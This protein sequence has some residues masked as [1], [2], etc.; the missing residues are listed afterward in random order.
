MLLY[1]M[2]EHPSVS[3]TFVVTEAA[4]VRALGVP[5]AG[6]A[7]NRGAAL[8]PAAELDFL[9]PPPGRAALVAGALRS[10]RAALRPL[11]RVA[12]RELSLREAV[13]VVLAEAHAAHVVSAARRVGVVHVHAHFLGRSADVADALARR[14]GC[15][16]TV[17]AHA[18]DVYVPPEPGLLRDR[19]ARTA[20]VA[21]ASRNVRQTVE[22]LAAGRPVRTGIVHCGVDLSET[23]FRDE[24]PAGGRRGLVTVGRLVATKGYWTILAS[25]HDLLRRHPELHW[26]L[27][28]DGP[29]RD[30]LRADPRFA[31]L[32]PRLVLAGA[33]D[34]AQTLDL[35]RTADAFV[36]PSERAADGDSD[37]IP[38][39]LM[40]AMGLGVPVVTTAVGG[41]PELVVDGDTGLVVP[42]SDPAALTGA[43]ERL[44]YSEASDDVERMRRA[45]R[46][47][48]E[49]EFESSGQAE[50]LL[51]LL[52]PWVPASPRAI[53]LST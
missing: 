20:A 23:T 27:V 21:C 31:D 48:V 44:L 17:T 28:G 34:H 24:H 35:I 15:R 18:A 50:A 6:Y 32:T 47:K 52:R 22:R 14:L 11:A 4:A 43:L 42:E 33:L 53:A 29:L 49:R 39:A 26:T 30:A 7:L 16:W 41:I 46:A 5:V 9:C 19:L 25:A 8:R 51:E 38:V 40:E 3:Q 2:H 13:R 1:V 10:G 37:G 12:R 36:L 45:A